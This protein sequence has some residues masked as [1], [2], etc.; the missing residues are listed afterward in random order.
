MGGWLKNFHH[1][2]VTFS[3]ES[4]RNIHKWFQIL[5]FQEVHFG[6]MAN[7]KL[8]PI[9]KDLKSEARKLGLIRLY[10]KLDTGRKQLLKYIHDSSKIGR[11]SEQGSIL[12]VGSTGVGKSS[13]KKK[14]FLLGIARTRGGGAAPARIKKYTFYIPLWRPK[15]MYKLPKRRG[16]VIWAMP[17]RKHS[18]LHE[19]FPNP[20]CSQISELFLKMTNQ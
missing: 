3:V 10:P 14:C 5:T 8:K 16:E 7:E 19:V 12:L 4:N 13:T 20:L 1:H 17:E 15:K 9:P 6:I 18:F 2:I 11:S